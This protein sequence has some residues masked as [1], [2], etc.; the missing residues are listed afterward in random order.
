MKK[1]KQI[2]ETERIIDEF[3][4]YTTRNMILLGK[5][6]GMNIDYSSFVTFIKEQKKLFIEEKGI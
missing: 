1:Q 3:I 2:T 6:I 5:I 4:T